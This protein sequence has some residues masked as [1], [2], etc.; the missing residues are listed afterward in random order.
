M[1]DCI[2]VAGMLMIC[3]YFAGGVIY[4]MGKQ[5]GR[6]ARISRAS[7]MSYIIDAESKGHQVSYGK[8]KKPIPSEW[9]D[10]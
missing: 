9:D 2:V 3:L 6:E 10:D 7:C 4:G 1:V 5:A 8:P